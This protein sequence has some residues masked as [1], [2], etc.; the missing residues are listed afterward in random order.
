MEPLGCGELR[1]SGHEYFMKRVTL[2][3][4]FALGLTVLFPFYLSHSG[5]RLTDD[6]KVSTG[7]NVIS[8]NDSVFLC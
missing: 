3:H 4:S 5:V 7:V 1:V 8:V 6:S 2:L